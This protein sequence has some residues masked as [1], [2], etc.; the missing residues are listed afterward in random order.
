MLAEKTKT[1][2]QRLIR[3]LRPWRNGMNRTKETPQLVLAYCNIA[4]SQPLSDMPDLWQTNKR[5]LNKRLVTEL[6]QGED[7]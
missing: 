6:N 1:N 2:I 4:A 5:R 7:K 3:H